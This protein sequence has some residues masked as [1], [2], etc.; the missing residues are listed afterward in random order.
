MNNYD[1]GEIILIQFVFSNIQQ[2]K[3]RPGLVLLDA[4]DEDIIVA[5]ITSR[6]HY[7]KFDLTITEW[8]KA[9]LLRPSTVRFHKINTL[10]KSLI[11]RRLGKLEPND[12]QKI[13]EKLA[14][15]WSFD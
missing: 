3:R 4:G 12:W 8:Q 11:N 1:S 5:K 9:G 7:T 14:E 15:L 10:S 2:T 6:P 13:K